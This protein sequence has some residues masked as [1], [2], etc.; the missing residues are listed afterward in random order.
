MLGKGD[1]PAGET[2]AWNWQIGGEV[3]LD[4]VP[5]AAVWGLDGFLVDFFCASIKSR[6]VSAGLAAGTKLAAW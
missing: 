2:K 6:N 3:V 1:L 4:G 5:R